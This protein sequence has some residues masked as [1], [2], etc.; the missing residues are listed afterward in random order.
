LKASIVALVF[1]LSACALPQ[2]TVRTGAAQP[3]VT[4][5]GAPSDAVLFVD[6]LSMGPAKQFDGNPNVLAVLEGVHTLEIH[7][8]STVIFHD[9]ALFSNGETHP[10]KLL[11]GAGQ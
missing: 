8:G 2:T 10:I 5:Q 3:G 9:K 4:V 7:Q 1:A 11:P 6:G